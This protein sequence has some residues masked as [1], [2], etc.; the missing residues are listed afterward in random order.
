MVVTAWTRP[1]AASL[2]AATLAAIG[3]AA[4]ADSVAQPPLLAEQARDTCTALIV[5]TLRELPP[6]AS[7][8]KRE[9]LLSPTTDI[10]FP[11]LWPATYYMNYQLN[12]VSRDNLE[13]TSAVVDAFNSAGWTVNQ[14]HL[15]SSASAPDGYTLVVRGGPGFTP[16]IDCTSPQFTYLMREQN[17]IG[18]P[19]GTLNQ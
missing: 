1:V 2:A 8:T 5:Q 4:S 3:V 9:V 15:R 7:A 10:P 13:A 12:W 6:G 19:P 18:E 14:G 11:P 16:Q 17:A